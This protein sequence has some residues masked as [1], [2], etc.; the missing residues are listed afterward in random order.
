MVYYKKDGG[1]YQTTINILNREIEK[2][3]KENKELK[4]KIEELEEYK[5]KYEELCK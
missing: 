3:K 1:F 4:D 2:L 5:W